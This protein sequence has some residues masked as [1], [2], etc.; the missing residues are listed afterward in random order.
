MG[1]SD[2][3]FS[4]PESLSSYLNQFPDQPERVLERL[5]SFLKKRGQ[6]AVGYM[7]LAW[8]YFKNGEKDRALTTAL[9]AKRYA[10]GSPLLEHFHYFLLHPD[11]FDAEIPD[12]A[13]VNRSA[14]DS[15]SEVSFDLEKLINRLSE[16][17]GSTIKE[18]DESPLSEEE[19]LSKKTTQIQDIATQ[20]L[21]S[22]Y[23]RQGKLEEAIT[24][25]EQL[26]INRPERAAE[27]DEEI[28]SLKARLDQQSHT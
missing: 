20:T 12:K 10:P 5:R 4:L 11:G 9:Q 8:L 23:E 21:A 28:K 24:I 19:D 15:Q 17:S 25:Y 16:T 22:I 13:G 26:K 1:M 27:F 6:D 2:F 3:P 7:L 18:P 14:P